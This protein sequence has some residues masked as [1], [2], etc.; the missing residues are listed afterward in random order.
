M[1]ERFCRLL[2]V[3]LGVMCLQHPLQAQDD[4]LDAE[5]VARKGGKVRIIFRNIP[6]EDKQNVDGDYDVSNSDG[7]INLP[8]LSSRVYVHGKTARQ[9]EDIIRSLYVDQKIYSRPIVSASLASDA[10]QEAYRQRRVTVSGFVVQQKQ[11]PYRPGI[12]LLQAIVEC[13]GLS[14]HGSRRVTVTR[15]NHVRTYDYFS[16]KDR[17]L[18]L[19]PDDQITVE[20]RGPFEARPDKLVP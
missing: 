15:G 7:T 6:A 10:E 14:Q 11:V 19:R 3:L 18:K 8:Y 13:G 17:T 12:T 5:M 2:F 1:F 9:L 4:G 20:K 16:A